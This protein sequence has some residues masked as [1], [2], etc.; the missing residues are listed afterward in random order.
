[1]NEA[2]PAVRAAVLDVIALAGK[3]S[4]L[5]TGDDYATYRTASEILLARFGE[6]EWLADSAEIRAELLAT[7]L[8]YR[9][10]GDTDDWDPG[11]GH[12]A[13]RYHFSCAVCRAADR[14][15][16]LAAVVDK[17]INLAAPRRVP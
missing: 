8:G 10:A 5:W 7:N 9:I 15:E 13:H 3:H 17:I 6:P 2:E 16:A 4:D 12:A 1:M 14:P 11:E